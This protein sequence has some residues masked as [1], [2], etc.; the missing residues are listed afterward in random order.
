MCFTQPKIAPHDR[1]NWDGDHIIH[2]C[3][4]PAS[5][6]GVYPE[7]VFPYRRWGCLSPGLSELQLSLTAKEGIFRLR[8]G[9]KKG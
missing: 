3:I 7:Y 5:R 1:W 8:V 6:P 9:P 4:V 2:E